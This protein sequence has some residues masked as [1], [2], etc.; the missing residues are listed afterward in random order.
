MLSYGGEFKAKGPALERRVFWVPIRG[1]RAFESFALRWVCFRIPR[2][3]EGG[4]Y[5]Y[6]DEEEDEAIAL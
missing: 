3:H 2:E 1:L 6:N 5:D 4:V